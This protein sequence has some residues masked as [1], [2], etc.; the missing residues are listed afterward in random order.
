ML[1]IQHPSTISLAKSISDL[2]DAARGLTAEEVLDSIAT[3]IDHILGQGSSYLVFRTL[4]LIYHVDRESVA[5]NLVSFQITISKMMGQHL[6][7]QIALLA[8]EDMSRKRIRI[9]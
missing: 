3:S 4:A 2:Q 5:K 6:A 8:A 1:I 7:D 9:S